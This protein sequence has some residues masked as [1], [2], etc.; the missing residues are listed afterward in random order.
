M[1]APWN[2][3]SQDTK[4]VRALIC[5]TVWRIANRITGDLTSTNVKAAAQAQYNSYHTGTL[6]Q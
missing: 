1:A 4:A 5:D 6:P 3:G 2:N